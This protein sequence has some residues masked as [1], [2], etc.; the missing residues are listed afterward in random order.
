MADQETSLRDDID[1]A[2]SD[3]EDTTEENTAS[4]IQETAAP[5]TAEETQ[6]EISGQ[7]P[8]GDAA[9]APDAEADAVAAPASQAP[10]DWAPE[11]KAKWS[12]LSPDVQTAIA[13]REAHINETLRDTAGIRQ[14]YDEF[15]AMITP[16]A[17]LMQAEGATDPRQAIQGLLNTTATLSMG[18]AQQKAD[19]IAGMINHYGIDIEILDQILSGQV[20]TAQQA[21]P[22]DPR[23]DAI[24]QRMQNAEQQQT[25]QQQAEAASTIETFAADPA[26]VHFN[27]VKLAM[28]DFIDVAASHGQDMTLEEAYQRACLSDPRIA[29]LVTQ[30]LNA[31]I[32]QGHQS[33]VSGARMAAGSLAGK[34]A[35]SGAGAG[36]DE[37]MSLRETI[38]SQFEGGRR[39]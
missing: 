2:I 18:S 13:A 32:A 7:E 11:V 21:P 9:P 16:Y 38:A 31:Q 5:E 10:V 8:T 20:V 22:S 28:A 37:N 17:P 39:I 12:E 6:E 27:D 14:E 19:K 23:I 15:N 1:A 33:A 25:Q 36:L 30:N 26:N 4:A 29:P 35:A 34:P 3:V 24:W